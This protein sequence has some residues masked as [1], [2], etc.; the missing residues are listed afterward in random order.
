MTEETKPIRIDIVSDV[1]CPWCIIG[2]KQLQRTL[3]ELDVPVEVHWQPFELNPHM[4][5][6]GQDLREHVQWKYGATPAQSEATRQRI[7]D[8]GTALGFE[9]RYSEGMRMRNTLK[10]HQLLHWA[11]EQGKQ[12]ELKLELFNA[13]FTRNENVDDVAVLA[14]AAE[15]VGLDR[16][17]A[18]A[19]LEDGRYRHI[20]KE[21]AQSWHPRGIAAVP[22]FIY[23]GKYMIPGAQDPAVHLKVFEKILNEEAAH[24]GLAA[25][26]RPITP[27]YP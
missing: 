9:F 5:A 21:I 17:E 22:T 11:D 19:V 27:R 16:T 23:N 15:R 18:A 13:Y 1:V 24:R 14:S 3:A 20:V 7:A 10:A 26:Q 6:D 4:P 12:T 2:Y 8:A 25:P